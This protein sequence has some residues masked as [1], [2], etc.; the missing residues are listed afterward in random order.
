MLETLGT[1]GDSK[2]MFKQSKKYKVQIL[3]R[4]ANNEK[5]VDMMDSQF[6]VNSK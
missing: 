1:F 4:M 5:I 6:Y 3:G 2:N